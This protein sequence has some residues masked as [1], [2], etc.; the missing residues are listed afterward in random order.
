MSQPFTTRF[1]FLCWAL[2]RFEDGY[3]NDADRALIEA[4][5]KISDLETSEREELASLLD[6]R[7]K[8]LVYDGRMLGGGKLAVWLVATVAAALLQYAGYSL[9]MPIPLLAAW[10]FSLWHG[11]RKQHLAMGYD[12]LV[13]LCI[14]EQAVNQRTAL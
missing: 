10:G 4:H 5:T 12:R 1:Q 2:S 7:A 8:S 3:R 13:K 11:Y 6:M 9:Q 14:S